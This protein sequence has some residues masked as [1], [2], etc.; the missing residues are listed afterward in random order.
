MID[1]AQNALEQIDSFGSKLFLVKCGSSKFLEFPVIKS[2][3][4]N[5]VVKAQFM[6]KLFR[7]SSKQ[8]DVG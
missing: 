1:T 5:T 8:N 3:K 4:Y 7:R 2:T 6:L